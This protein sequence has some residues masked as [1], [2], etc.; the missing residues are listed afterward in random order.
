MSDKGRQEAIGNVSK[1][2]QH[3]T[4]TSTQRNT[5][6]MAPPS[7]EDKC[8][9]EDCAQGEGLEEGGYLFQGSSI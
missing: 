9:G 7:A 2:T 5:Q 8:G 3:S 6:K 4:L 1:S